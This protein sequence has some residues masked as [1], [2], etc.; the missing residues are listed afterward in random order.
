M[1]KLLNL[2]DE[3]QNELQGMLE[4][5]AQEI[6]TE[7][8]LQK[9]NL[10]LLAQKSLSVFGLKKTEFTKIAKVYF[11]DSIEEETEKALMFKKL[12]M[13]TLGEA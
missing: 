6:L 12:Y 5:E 4:G 3:Q 9:E 7:I 2:T 1:E 13:E 8:E 10:D 11:K